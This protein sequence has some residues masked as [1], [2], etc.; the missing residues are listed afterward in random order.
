[1]AVKSD[2]SPV[3]WKRVAQS[4]L[5]AG[6]AVSAADPSGFVG[7]VQEAFAAG[8]S[9]SQAKNEAGEGGLAKAVATELLTAS[10][11][12][13]AREG[14]RTIVQGAGLDEIKQRALDALRETAAILDARAPAEARSFKTWLLEIAEKVAEAGNEDTFLGFGGI[15][16]SA[17]EKATLDEISALLGLE[18]PNAPEAT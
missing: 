1:M 15:R 9:L 4:P 6:F 3:E 7:L 14:V 8:Q 16:M 13:E 11:R 5:L 18:R 12:A 2:F 17:R 10:G